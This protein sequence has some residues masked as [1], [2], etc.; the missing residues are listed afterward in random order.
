MAAG[1]SSPKQIEG[2][3]FCVG[4]AGGRNKVGKAKLSDRLLGLKFMQRKAAKD[5]FKIKQRETEKRLK[6]VC[7]TANALRFS[8]MGLHA[9]LRLTLWSYDPRHSPYTS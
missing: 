8:V 2:N 1:Y 6:E 9:N 5:E 7:N 4:N 3:E